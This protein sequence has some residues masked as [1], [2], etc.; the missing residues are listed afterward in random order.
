MTWSN[1]VSDTAFIIL[2][3]EFDL[4]E[5]IFAYYIYKYSLTVKNNTS[6]D[7]HYYNTEIHD[8]CNLFQLK[9]CT[10]SKYSK[11]KD[12]AVFLLLKVSVK[13]WKKYYRR[14]TA[15]VQQICHGR[16]DSWEC[17]KGGGVKARGK[18]YSAADRYRPDISLYT[19]YKQNAENKASFI[20][21]PISG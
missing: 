16:K 20:P 6:T 4:T 7:M 10:A 18:N 21:S 12:F 13:S 17:S 11:I 19:I 3:S 14:Q 1:I 9:S 2:Q 8:A 5:Y 15:S